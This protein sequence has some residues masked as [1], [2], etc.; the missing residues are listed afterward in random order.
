MK[1]S[2]CPALK[3]DGFYHCLLVYPMKPK[4]LIDSNEDADYCRIWETYSAFDEEIGKQDS[5]E[6]FNA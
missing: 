2:E 6:K 4:Q 5:G 1:C 3:L